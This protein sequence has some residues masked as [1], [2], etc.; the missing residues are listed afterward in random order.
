MGQPNTLHF[1]SLHKSLIALNER[2]LLFFLQKYIIK[3]TNITPPG[4]TRRISLF[5]R[6]RNTENHL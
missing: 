4:T 3:L 5:K 6:L 1:Q 2:Y